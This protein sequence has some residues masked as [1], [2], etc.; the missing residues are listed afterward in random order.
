MLN[1]P[2]TRRST[3]KLKIN[4][5]FH[6]FNEILKPDFSESIW[7]YHSNPNHSVK[8]QPVLMF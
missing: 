8:R 1:E 3:H 7:P 2:I 5:T 4:S 6:N